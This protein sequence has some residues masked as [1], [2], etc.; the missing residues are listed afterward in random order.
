MLV[1]FY[2]ISFASLAAND[3]KSPTRETRDVVIINPY[4]DGG[5]D[6][7]LAN[8]IANTVLKEGGRA[9]IVPVLADYGSI[10]PV[11]KH[12]NVYHGTNKHD[13]S[14]LE[15]PAFIIAPAWILDT[16][17]LEYAVNEV[18]NQF[19]FNKMD[20]FIIE[21][22]DLLTAPNQKSSQIESTLYEL[23]FT[24]VH[25][26]YN[27]GFGKDFI[28]YLSMKNDV[29]SAQKSP[30]AM[31]KSSDLEH[32]SADTIKAFFKKT[33]A[34]QSYS[35]MF[36]KGANFKKLDID[37]AEPSG[38]KSSLHSLQHLNSVS[39]HYLA[40]IIE[41]VQDLTSDERAL[42]SKVVN[43]KI[44]FRHQSN[45]NLV[46]AGGTLNIK[47]LNKLQSN[48]IST[49]SNTYSDD[50]RCLSNQDF[51]FFGVEFSDDEAQLPL[52]TRH[53]TVDFGGNA[54][55]VDGQFPHGYLTLTDHFDNT[56][57]P[58]YK[59]EHQEFIAQFSRV[60]REI[61]RKVHGDKGRIDIPIFSSKDMKLGL[62]L[63][64]I[65]FLRNSE[66]TEFKE[67]ALDEN[68]DAKNLDR[69]LNFVFQP[70]FHV[71]R[72]VST[73]HFTEVKL[74]DIS[75][76]EAVKASNFEAISV[77]LKNKDDAYEVM[78][79]AITYAKKDVVDLLFSKF[80][81]TRQDVMKM[82][83]FYDIQYN[84]SDYSADEKILK[85]FLE[86]GL[87]DPN[88]VFIKVNSGDT[89]LDNAFKYD[90]KEMIAI[91]LE[92]GAVRGSNN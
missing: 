87:V 8:S 38:R 82:S 18:S 50:I 5:D 75:L 52:N 42:L 51:V 19:G 10:H 64:L 66:D 30:D 89:M 67:F 2:A 28:G 58:A 12:R 41:K 6:R 72:M 23:G 73:D 46:D 70:E 61:F 49:A 13:I 84:L 33:I 15:E 83:T 26:Y 59:H 86:R 25:S 85:E 22:M 90:K 74:R 57:P 81:F 76:K 17:A 79:H 48:G 7:D 56:V 9:S 65:D 34:A 37:L 16:A 43:A 92:Y 4:T 44:H 47:S 40:K 69:I 45:S 62:G 14:D 55:I 60:K 88:H 27:L 39:K 91:L 29:I 63:H 11:E 36:S 20:A 68:L 80:S 77:Y 32:R 78:E 3:D 24:R 71:P 1:V 21:E 53:T 31:P 54:Y 35:E